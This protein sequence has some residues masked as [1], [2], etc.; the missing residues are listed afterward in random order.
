MQDLYFDLNYGK[1]YEAVESGVCEIFEFENNLGKVRHLFLKRKIPN[2]INGIQYYDLATPYGYGGPLMIEV[3]EENKNVVEEKFEEA[4]QNYC[5]QNNVVSE[6]VRFHP[7]FLNAQ[8]FTK[9][10]D[11]QHRRYTTGTNLQAHED[12][13]QAE[14]SKSTRRNIR[15]AIKAGVTVDISVNPKD[16]K[17]F[18]EVYYST[19]K[20]NN[21]D[22]IYYFNNQYFSDCLKLLG[23][24]VVLTEVNYGSRT[25]GMGLSFIYNKSIHTHLSGTLEEYHHLS[26]AYLLQYALVVWGKENGYHLIHD[27]GGRTSDPQDKLFLFKKQFGKNTI[28]DYFVGHKIWNKEIYE[29]LCKA[30]IASEETDFFPAYRTVGAK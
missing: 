18:Q 6:F 3:L 19:M 15:N 10:Y 23:K 24:H 7:L 26:P 1:L 28:F 9:I 13:V 21:A 17:N 29:E 2:L 11:V 22:S 30:T 8:D 25:I 27:G 20:R 4:F 12:P 14:F 5:Q 16:L